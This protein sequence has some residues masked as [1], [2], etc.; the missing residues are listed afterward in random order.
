M[1]V[2]VILD[3]LTEVGRPTLNMGSTISENGV[4]AKYRRKQA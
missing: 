2:R 1:P 4:Q 3:G